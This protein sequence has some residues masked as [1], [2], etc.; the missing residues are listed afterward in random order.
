MP[1]ASGTNCGCDNDIVAWLWCLWWSRKLIYNN[2][3]FVIK[4][5]RQKC[6]MLYSLECCFQKTLKMVFTPV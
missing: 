6:L 5:D 4:R 2:G 3:Q 1:S